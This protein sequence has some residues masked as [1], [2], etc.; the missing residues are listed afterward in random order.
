MQGVCQVGKRWQ[1][2]IPGRQNSLCCLIK[3]GGD[4]CAWML[5]AGGG[6]W[7]LLPGRH[8][9]LSPVTYPRLYLWPPPHPPHPA[10]SQLDLG[11][12]RPRLEGSELLPFTLELGYVVALNLGL[13]FFT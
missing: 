5:D 3:L 2:C 6:V 7:P 4:Q 9:A 11:V 12:R 8:A 1:D 13:S 10:L